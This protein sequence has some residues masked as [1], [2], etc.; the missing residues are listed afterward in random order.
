MMDDRSLEPVPQG[1]PRIRWKRFA[2]LASGVVTFVSVVRLAADAA[3]V[4]RGTVA[5]SSVSAVSMF[6]VMFAIGTFAPRVMYDAWPLP[7]WRRL[8]ISLVFSL[9]YAVCFFVFLIS[10][11]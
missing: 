11:R 3:G 4:Q 6:V 1:Q 8:R 2:L 9:G 7:T 5:S 10:T